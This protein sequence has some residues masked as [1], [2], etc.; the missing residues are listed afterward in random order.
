MEKIEES[1]TETIETTDLDAINADL[2]EIVI[3]SV[4]EDGL[5][6]DLPIVNVVVGLGNFGSK[7]HKGIFLKK[8]LSFLSNLDS[9]STEERKD[10]VAVIIKATSLTVQ[11]NKWGYIRFC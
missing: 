10:F 3:D 9:T 4:L 6:K 7:I 11:T 1:L 5:L 2:A 8:V